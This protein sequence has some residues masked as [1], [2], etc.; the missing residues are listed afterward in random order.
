MVP[1]ALAQ[2]A[3][4]AG[5]HR[6]RRRRTGP[7][8]TGRRRAAAGHAGRHRA[9]RAATASGP[10]GRASTAGESA[11]PRRGPSRSPDA[12]RRRRA[13]AGR[14]ARRLRD[15][16]D[17]PRAA[18]CSGVVSVRASTSERYQSSSCRS[19]STPSSRN[20]CWA[21]PGSSRQP[22]PVVRLGDALAGTEAVV[23]RAAHEA[24]RTQPVVHAAA[25]VRPRCGH[26]TPGGLVDREVRGD[27]RTS[28]PRSRS[29]RTGCSRR[30][31]SARRSGRRSVTSRP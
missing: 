6:S 31:S 26:G 29:R 19:R 15:L 12:A 17:Q 21:V 27:R 30:D 23:D 11:S 28:V 24:Q 2:V 25:V 18:S 1:S 16:L 5:R 8:R 7:H 20:I 4:Y 3:A 10:P 14:R 9:G 13:A 22:V